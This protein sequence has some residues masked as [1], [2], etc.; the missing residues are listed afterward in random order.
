M[1]SR[2]K[3]LVDINLRPLVG[4]SQKQVCEGKHGVD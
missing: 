2:A 3:D 1:R 4:L